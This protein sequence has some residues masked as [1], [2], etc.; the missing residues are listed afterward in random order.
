MAE[1]LRKKVEQH[2]FNVE[3]NSITLT[4]S[5]GVSE[6]KQG[7]NLNS[8]LRNADQNLYH[9]KNQGRNSVR[10]DEQC[11]SEVT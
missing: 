3:G 11:F 7:E 9:A 8:F 4:V 2:T 6:L 5:I 1:M 10:H